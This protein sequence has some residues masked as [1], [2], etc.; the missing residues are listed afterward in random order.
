M[1]NRLSASMFSHKNC[2]LY[3]VTLLVSSLLTTLLAY[4]AIKVSAASDP[5]NVRVNQIG[6]LPIADK[7]ATVISSSTSALNWELRDAATGTAVAAGVTSVYGFDQASGDSVHKANFSSFTATGSYKLWVSGVGTSAAFNITN[8]LYPTLTK[9][10]MAYFYFHRMGTPIEAA[11]LAEPAYAHS[12]LH[13]GDSAIPCFRSWCSGTLNVQK[14]WADAGDFGI[15]PV[16]HAISAWALLNSYERNPS[17]MTDGY[18]N[19]PEKSNGI[20][21][22]LD[23]VRF[24]SEYLRGIL[25]VTGLASHKIT[26]DQWSAFVITIAGENASSRYAQPPSTNATYAVARTLAQLARVYATFDSAYAS[27]VWAIAKDAYNRAETLPVVLYTSSTVDSPGGGDYDDT[28]TQDDRYAASVEMYLTAHQRGDANKLMY[29][30]NVTGSSEYK[31]VGTFYWGDVS[32]LGSLSL[33]SAANDLPASDL[34]AIKSNAISAANNQLAILNGE[35]YPSSLPGSIKY[36]WGSNSAILHNMIEF[37]YAYDLTSD[38]KY[39]KAM[40]RN[41][42]YMMGNNA[43]KQSY[44][45]GYGQYSETDTHDRWAWTVH[46]AT[47]V[48]YPKGWISG[49]PNNAIISD[50]ATPIVASAKSYAAS[51]TAPNA[52]A[53]KENTINWNAPLVWVAQYMNQKKGDLSSGST[54]SVPS[55]PTGVTAT[56]GNAQVSLNWMASSGATSY[57]V[58]RSE[59]PGGAYNIVMA[60]ISGTSYS[61]TGLTNGTTYYYVVNAVNSA[62]ASVDSAQASATP[63][64]SGAGTG[65]KLVAQYKLN[66]TNATDN[67]I[68]ATFNIKNNGTSAVSLSG[69]KLRYYFTKDGSQALNYFIDWAQIGSANVSGAFVS[70]IGNSAD[71]YLEVSFGAGAGSIAPGGQSGDIQV[72]ITKSDWSNFNESGD[73]SFD[74]TKNVFAD[75]NKITLYQNGSLVWGIAP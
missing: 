71:T 63:S 28:T 55:V 39:L 46:T 18:L 66:N 31:K 54:I 42:D 69:L 11:Y 22:V 61:D 6:Y 2:R 36:D 53:S 48:P 3:L 40:Y 37:A 19:I 45:T 23:E 59:T 17:G 25:P 41:M 43:M 74:P 5:S 1:H 13:P 30:S 32:T 67:T 24:G 34:N 68:N 62:G 51:G 50:T 15:Y 72:R 64:G 29:K 70:T 27:Q 20:P 60:G 56:A 7:I 38:L 47:G 49:G 75:W 9:D 21:D 65:G 8:D 52:W 35:G 14:S 44:I 73:Y 10:A 58:K 26:N 16:N 4:S 12:A 57:T 33:L